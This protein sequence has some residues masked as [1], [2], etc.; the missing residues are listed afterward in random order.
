MTTPQR[1]KCFVIMPLSETSEAHTEE[2]WNKHFTKFLKPLIE[3]GNAFEAV[4]SEA[5]RG[6]LL[7]QIV[8]YLVTAPLVVAE[9]TDANPN[10]YW[11]LGVRQSFKHRTITIAE[12]GTKLPFD[13]STKGTIFYYPS[14]YIK[15][16]EKFKDSFSSA[17][18]D[19]LENPD[20]PDSYVLE[21]ISGRGTLYQILMRDES[22][23]RLDALIAEIQNNEDSWNNI[24]ELAGQSSKK[25]RIYPTSILHDCCTELL[26]STRYISADVAFYL[27]AEDYLDDIMRINERVSH[28][29]DKVEMAEKWIGVEAEPVSRTMS[30]FKT[31]VNQQKETIDAIS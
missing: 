17:I 10:V 30:E 31:L 11:E 23:R 4:R 1:L 9:L 15:M 3:S 19:C 20:F 5:L 12:S 18:K 13:L 22:I 24:V 14:D 7:R 28:W 26:V 27:K 2:Y 21:A 16:E 8:T 25:P 6:D 29:T